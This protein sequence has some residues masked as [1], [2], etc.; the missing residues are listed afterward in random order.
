MR[1]SKVVVKVSYREVYGVIFVLACCDGNRRFVAAK[2][3]GDEDCSMGINVHRYNVL[4]LEVS[5]HMSVVQD[6]RTHWFQAQSPDMKSLY[7]RLPSLNSWY[8]T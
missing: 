4:L 2:D 3:D 6:I 5:N 8:G 1:S 7:R